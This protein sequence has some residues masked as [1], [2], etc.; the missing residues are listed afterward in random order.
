MS[1]L[2]QSHEEVEC[3]VVDDAST[4]NSVDVILK[5]LEQHPSV[6]FIQNKEN[7]GNC[8]SF[9]R[10]LAEAS[11]DYIIDLA[12]DDILHTDRVLAGI[13]TFQN[14]SEEYGVNYCNALHINSDGH[15]LGYQY[16]VDVNGLAKRKPPEGDVFADLV[17]R[18][19]L[20]APTMMMR[21]KV[22]T[23]LG[24]YDESLSYEDFDFWV[25]SS[26]EF[27]YCYT[28]T[29]LIRKRDLKSSLAGKQTQRGNNHIKTNI[30][31]CGKA[32]QLART[33]TEMQALRKRLRFEIRNCVKTGNKVYIK[34]FLSLLKKQ[35]Y[36]DYILYYVAT[37]PW[38]I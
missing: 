17:A 3:I 31:V 36:T 16:D 19:W 15:E 14:H 7:Q 30:K 1:A 9:N 10:A 26:R 6:K 8:K 12:A 24:G 20:S 34:E 5:V 32:M 22:L 27:K 35:S 18:F 28:D 29:V 2:N 13:E 4:D 11:G 21:R 38:R 23:Q 33:A 25:R 37:L